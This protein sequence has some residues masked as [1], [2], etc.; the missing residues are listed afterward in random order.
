MA[1][2]HSMLIVD[3]ESNILKSLKRLLIDTDYNVLTCES[4][5]EGLEKLAENEVHLVISD[6]RMPGMDGVEFLSKVKE[7]YPETIRLILSGFA[8]AAAM[9][10]A[11]NDGQV[12]KF[13]A[14]P[15]NDQELL[16]TIMRA[17]EQYDLQVENL[18]LYAKLKKSNDHLQELTRSLEEEV[19]IRTMDLEVKNSALKVSQRIL[20]HLPV[21]V[22]GIDANGSVVYL[23]RSLSRFLSTSQLCLGSPISGVIDSEIVKAL[24]SALVEERMIYK[25]IN[26][27]AEMGIVCSPLKDNTGA[28]GVFYWLGPF[29]Q[30]DNSKESP[31]KEGVICGNQS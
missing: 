1:E 22:L 9:I 20:N 13:I 16:T 2:Q 21:G 12:Y 11:I 10:G 31:E 30:F 3:D 24:M 14:K 5:A 25:K 18:N 27:Q 23:N 28:I 7:I 19:K 8:D 26:G 6:Y 29:E 15:W 17:F 4:G